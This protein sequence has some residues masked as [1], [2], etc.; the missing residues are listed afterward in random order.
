M[1]TQVDP[2][3]PAGVTAVI[4]V[5]DPNTTSDARL[6]PMVTAKGLPTIKPDPVI[7]TA[8]PPSVVPS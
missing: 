5:E 6:P 8:V 2:A 4:E 3:V 1:L 7:V